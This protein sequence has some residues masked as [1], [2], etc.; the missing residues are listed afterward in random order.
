[1]LIRGFTLI[2]MVICLMILGLLTTLSLPLMSRVDSVNKL[3][4][5]CHLNQVLA[6]AETSTKAISYQ[7]IYFHYNYDGN[8]S[9]ALSID[10]GYRTIV[11]R[12]GFG[13]IRHE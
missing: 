2:E 6:I 8:I 11:F 12:L 1:M 13:H 9:Q 7:D 10:M 4:S 3:I 5:E